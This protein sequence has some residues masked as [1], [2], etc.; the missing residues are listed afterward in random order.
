ME[1]EITERS[2]ELSCKGLM[3]ISCLASLEPRCAAATCLD[4]E[5][6]EVVFATGQICGN[7][8]KSNFMDIKYG[9]EDVG[10][11]TSENNY[12]TIIRH[13]ERKSAEQLITT[14]NIPQINLSEEFYDYWLKHNLGIYLQI[15]IDL[16]QQCFSSIK[17][18]GLVSEKDP[19]TGEEWLVIDVTVEGSIADVLNRYDQYTDLWVA[20]VPWPQR[21]K[22][23]LS[24]DII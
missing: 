12:S 21:D 16:I 23:R 4:L 11:F 10:T 19:D 13:H 24:Y 1:A 14:S 20:L 5:E 18:I 6:Y 22:I 8:V 17:T 2:R 3:A 7:Y 15:A 9:L